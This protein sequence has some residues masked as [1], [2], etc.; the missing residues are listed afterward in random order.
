MMKSISIFVLLTAIVTTLSAQSIRKTE[1]IEEEQVPVSI[2][3]AFENDFGKISEEGYWTASFI[4]EKD[5]TRTAA[6][7]LSY[8]YHKKDKSNK[9]E[10]RYAADG[11]LES[12]KGIEK[13]ADSATR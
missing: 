11:K 12:V 1:R 9:I 10:V 8:T 4:L 5:G 3:A 6:K 13:K 2:R 7:P